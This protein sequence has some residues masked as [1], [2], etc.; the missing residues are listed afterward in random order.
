MK[1]AQ[2]LSALLKLTKGY[3]LH[4]QDSDEDPRFVAKLFDMA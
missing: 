1:K 2:F 3:P 4:S